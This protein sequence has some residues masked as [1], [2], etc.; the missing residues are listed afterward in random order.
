M[1]AVS[2]KELYRSPNGDRWSLWR[3]SSGSLAVSHQPNPASGGRASET[4]VTN[5][6]S[7]GGHGPEHRALLEALRELG[8]HAGHDV[9]PAR[10]EL[11]QEALD[12]VSR[13]LGHAVAACWS[14]LDQDAQQELF[15]AA[16]RSEGETIRHQL[17][18]FLH[19]K[20]ARTQHARH[21][22]ALPEPD[23][24]GG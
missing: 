6:L 14:N 24:L 12:A 1:T 8:M 13:A 17:A 9:P 5:F 2:I 11:P 19:G 7:A 23:S 21:A 16:V 22:H 18:I 20:H 15:E 10:E 3:N 4:D